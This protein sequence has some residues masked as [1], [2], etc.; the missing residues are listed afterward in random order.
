MSTVACYCEKNRLT[1]TA[2]LAAAM[3]PHENDPPRLDNS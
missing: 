2:G 3:N 1:V